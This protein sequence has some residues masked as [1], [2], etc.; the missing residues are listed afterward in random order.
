MTSTTP[1]SPNLNKAIEAYKKANEKVHAS[2]KGQSIQQN[3]GLGI[4]HTG[5]KID[6]IEQGTARPESFAYVIQEIIKED[7]QKIKKSEQVA[8]D[9]IK[10][11]ANMVEIMA[12]INE[13]EVVLHEIVTIRNTLLEA[14][15]SIINTPL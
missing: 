3:D 10:G 12:A 14:Y 6:V 11:K 5:D 4:L 1:I 13:S 15:K 7:V 8:M 9:A 2:S